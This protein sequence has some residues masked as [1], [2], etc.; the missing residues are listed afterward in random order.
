MAILPI[1][2]NNVLTGY[3]VSVNATHDTNLNRLR[4]NIQ[5]PVLRCYQQNQGH[6]LKR[7][8]LLGLV[9]PTSR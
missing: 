3:Q 4:I 8:L 7:H 2:M 9:W 5:S 1:F 6:M